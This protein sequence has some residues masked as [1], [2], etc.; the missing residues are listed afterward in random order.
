MQ[1]QESRLKRVLR[2]LNIHRF[3]GFDYFNYTFLIIF[4]F[5]ALYPFIYVFAGAFNE[6]MDYM[7]GGVY[8]W[9]RVFSLDNF[10]MIFND[11][12]LIIGFRNTIARTI[13]GV[14]TGTL[15]TAMVAYAMSR[16]DLPFRKAINRFNI[17]TLFFSG[18][19]I[20][21]F[22]VLKYLNLLNNFWVYIIPYLYSVFNMIIL[23]SYFRE[24]PEEIHESAII[25]GAGEPRIFWN[26]YLPISK[27]IIATIALWIGVFHWNSFFDSMVFTTDSSLQTLQFFLVTLIKEASFAQGEAAARVPAQV[28]RSTSITTIRYAAIVVSTIPILAIYPFMQRYLIKG[29]MVGSV[30]G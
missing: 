6:G 28:V 13:I 21:Y 2:K 10:K 30:K 5:I 17:F 27:P 12:R 16:N 24:V 7:R 8:F 19:L 29:I 11:S 14:I 18:G 26:L 3:N 1:Q 4:S 20:P 9:P 22:M 25:D 15:F 23:Q